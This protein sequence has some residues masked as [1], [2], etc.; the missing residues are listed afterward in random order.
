MTAVNTRSTCGIIMMPLKCNNEHS[1]DFQVFAKKTFE[2]ISSH[3]RRVENNYICVVVFLRRV[4]AA[5][6]SIFVGMRNNSNSSNNSEPSA[7]VKGL[8][9]T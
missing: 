5:S 1:F 2:C 6:L 3:K 9:L 4:V 8:G 7:H